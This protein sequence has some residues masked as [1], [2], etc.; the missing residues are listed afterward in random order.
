M[1]EGEG[2]VNNLPRSGGGSGRGG[3]RWWG[4]PLLPRCA[5]RKDA[6]LLLGDARRRADGFA[7]VRAAPRDLVPLVSVATGR[8]RFVV[9]L[10]HLYDLRLDVILDVVVIIVVVILIMITMFTFV[11]G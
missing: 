5:H 7:T 3:R 6:S 10:D 1:V 11:R 2:S 8:E 9:I 4:R